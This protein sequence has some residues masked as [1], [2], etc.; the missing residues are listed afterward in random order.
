MNYHVDPLHGGCH[1]RFI[2]HVAG[3]YIDLLFDVRVVEFSDVERGYTLAF[4][5]KMPDKIDPKKN[6]PLL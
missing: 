3:D 2:A 5:Q 1:C 6:Q 4:C